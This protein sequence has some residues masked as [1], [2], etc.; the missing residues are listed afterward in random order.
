MKLFFTTD[1]HGSS[2]LFQ[3]AL[4]VAEDFEVDLLIIAGDLSGKEIIPVVQEGGDKF[5][6]SGGLNSISKNRIADYRELSEDSNDFGKY[7]L[8]LTVEE[9]LECL[10]DSKKA[11]KLA[12]QPVI[13]RLNSWIE[14]YKSKNYKYKLLISAGN[15]DSLE[16]DGVLK[17]YR[18]DNVI[19]GIDNVFNFQ[20]FCVVNYS[21]VPPTPWNTPREKS[22]KEI[23][24]EIK[25]I[26]SEASAP[27]IFNFH[28]PPYNTLLDGAPLVDDDNRIVVKGGQ[29][30][31]GHIGSKSVLD[32]IN[33]YQPLLS[34][35]GHIHE[36]SAEV[37]IKDT[38]CVNPGSEYAQGVL[39]GY[40]FEL[41]ANS[42]KLF[43]RIER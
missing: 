29:V 42:I 10:N 17:T 4:T 13:N 8:E 22:E 1:I 33:Q 25:A 18:N 32:L 36:S 39:R 2:L 15:D 9:Y 19:I 37:Y 43:H 7:M 26:L 35:H 23:E 16:L 28:C 38:L 27:Y 3:K 34:L 24:K 12:L 14:L 6:I 5:I 20:D 21:S 31:K 41:A 11:V 40:Y 30:Q